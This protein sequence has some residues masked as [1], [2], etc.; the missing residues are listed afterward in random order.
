MRLVYEAGA[1]AF[2]AKCGFREVARVTYK[3]D[4]L[5]YYELVITPVI[6]NSK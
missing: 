3:H 2:Y 5:V 6:A 1:G 4:P